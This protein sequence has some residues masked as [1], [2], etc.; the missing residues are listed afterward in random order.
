MRIN[1]HLIAD[2]AQA[3]PKEAHSMPVKPTAI[4][5]VD[6]TFKKAK[7]PLDTGGGRVS[8]PQCLFWSS[9]HC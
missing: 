4:S 1:F 7:E 2:S 8:L 5:G 6:L 9:G 3:T